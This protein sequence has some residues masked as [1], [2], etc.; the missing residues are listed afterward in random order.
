MN[1]K[2]KGEP[3]GIPFGLRVNKYKDRNI[4]T[5][6]NAVPI[7]FSNGTHVSVNIWNDIHF[8]FHCNNPKSNIYRW[9][10]V[11][12]ILIQSRT[13]DTAYKGSSNNYFYWKK[14]FIDVSLT[15]I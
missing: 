8:V 6:T 3:G 12:H 4:A 11:K 14:G 2:V 13:E 9:Y 15:G 7:L 1:G 5:N 10:K